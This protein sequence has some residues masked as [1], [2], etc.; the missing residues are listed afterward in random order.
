MMKDGD[1]DDDGD[2]NVNYIVHTIYDVIDMDWCE[3]LAH[4][5]WFANISPSAQ[6]HCG[7]TLWQQYEQSCK[8]F[9]VTSCWA[10]FGSM[11]C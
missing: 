6:S 7:L 8:N 5:L 10:M 4:T 9:C 1:D 3:V 11:S 2:A